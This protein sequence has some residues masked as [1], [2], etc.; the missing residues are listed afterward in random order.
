M[1]KF[2]ADC[3]INSRIGYIPIE[4]ES[5]TIVG[6]RDLMQNVYGAQQV[7]NL[8][9]INSFPF[10]QFL[11]LCSVILF[12]NYTGVVLAILFGIIG[13]KIAMKIKNFLIACLI[14][15]MMIGSGH[16]IGTTIRNEFFVTKSNVTHSVSTN[17]SI[18]DR[19]KFKLPSEAP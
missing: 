9:Q 7:L 15:M 8:H 11:F 5:Q 14:V 12:A 4:V 1:A 16:W 18:Y 10:G 6:A 3:W 2:K 13:F 17:D 19:L